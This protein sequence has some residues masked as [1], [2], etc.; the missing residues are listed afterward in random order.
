MIGDA[1]VSI[2]TPTYQRESRLRILHDIIRAQTYPRIEWLIHDDSPAPSEYFTG[3]DDPSVT[4]VHSAHRLGIS[5]KRNALAEM[6]SGD[7]IAHFDDDD[8]YAPEYVST[9][10]ERMSQGFDLVKLSG[11][12][13]YSASRGQLGYWDL[14]DIDCVCYRWDAT[15]T[16]AVVRMDASNNM[17]YRKNYLGF[18]FSYVYR[19]SLWESIGFSG[20]LGE[21]QIF[22][23]GAESRFRLSHFIDETG[24]CLHILHGS[25]SSACMPQYVLPRFLLPRLFPAINPELLSG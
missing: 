2:I 5:E 20:G 1:V 7:I 24:L 6:S 4:Y 12:F 23:E 21:D 10:V 11:W 15:R 14:N 3:L 22:I 18:G 17:N 13:L 16:T 19:K 8:Y 25:S 9:M